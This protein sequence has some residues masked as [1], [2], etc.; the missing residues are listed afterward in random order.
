MSLIQSALEKANR[1]VGGNAAAAAPVHKTSTKPAAPIK[2]PVIPK[3]ITRPVLEKKEDAG[4]LPNA[5]KKLRFKYPG[6][7]FSGI[8]LLA[9][10]GVFAGLYL[11]FSQP[12]AINKSSNAITSQTAPLKTQSPVFAK[13]KNKSRFQLSG[14]TFS[15]SDRLALVNNQVLGVGDKLSEG[16]MV[17]S[18]ADDSVILEFEGKTIELL[19]R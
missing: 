14:I 18:I 8:I 11:I 13:P 4:T 9:V 12:P 1:S 3:Q 6:L 10:L 2:T 16:A 7:V 19:L 15:G 17:K 5:P